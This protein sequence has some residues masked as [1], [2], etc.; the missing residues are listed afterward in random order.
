MKQNVVNTL[1]KNFSKDIS[2]TESTESKVHCSEPRV[3]NLG[4]HL[5]AEFYDCEPNILNNCQLIEDLMCEAA[6]RCGATIVTKD[7][8]MFSPYGVSGVVIIA[9]SHL[10]IHTWPEY[11]Y[12]AV[13]LFTCGD[14]CK[15]NVAYEFLREKLVSGA[16]FYSELTRGMMNRDTEEMIKMP[17]QV[18]CEQEH[19]GMR[20]SNSSLGG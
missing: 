12:A 9:E 5:L 10:A 7:F 1:P 6:E 18:R 16:A 13:D 3:F 2:L 15:P 14:S 11:G 20:I 4:Q 19:N 17:F 8:H